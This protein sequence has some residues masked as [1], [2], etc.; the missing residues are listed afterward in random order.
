MP[1]VTAQDIKDAGFFREMYAQMDDPAFETFLAG[2]ISSQA[3]LLASRIGAALYA[4]TDEPNAGYV[5]QAEKHLTITEMWKR[6]IARKLGQSQGIDITCKYEIESRDQAMEE[7]ERWIFRLTGGDFASG[8][9][10]TSRF[11]GAGDA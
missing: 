10:E 2:A 3:S 1:R 7:A 6:R 11:D 4:S 9:V 5:L 8:V